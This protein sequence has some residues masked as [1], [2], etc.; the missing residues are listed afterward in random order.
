MKRIFTFTFSLIFAVLM[1]AQVLN[2]PFPC[3]APP[4]LDPWLKK[5][6]QDPSAFDQRSGDTLIVALKIHL[7]ANDNGTARLDNDKFLNTFCQLQE[8]FAASGI[9][10]YMKDG[11][12]LINSTAW[13]NHTDI[14]QGI[15][16]MLSNNVPDAVNCYFVLNPAGNCGYNLPYGG[17]A[18]N[19]SCAGTGSHTWVHELGHAFTMPHPFIGW[20]GKTYNYNNPTPL[21]LTYDYTNFH[22]TL[23]I[24]QAPLDT[25]LVE[26][27]DGS[28]CLD[29][30][31]RFCLTTPD[32]LSYRWDCN[33]NNE[34]LVVQKDP[35]G[36]DFRSD[37]TL[38]MGYASDECQNRFTDDQIA[39][40]RANLVSE[41]GSLLLPAPPGALITE[42][43]GL[44]TPVES[45]LTPYDQVQLKWT[46][47]PG[48]TQYV[49]QV[50]RINYF[51][52]RDFETITSDTSVVAGS[53]LLNK[54]YYWRIRPFNAYSACTEWSEVRKFTTTA[55]TGVDVATGPDFS[56]FPTLSDG[57]S[58]FYIQ[59]SGENSYPVDA[60]LTDIHGKILASNSF[61]SQPSQVQAF[62]PKMSLSKG[63]YFLTLLTDQQRM[64]QK[65]IVH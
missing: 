24:G 51:P 15:D 23:D 41:K 64:V 2:K 12:D 31:D 28:N 49:V 45:Q 5:Y 65:I 1:Q 38:Y 27:V 19:H 30:A 35:N 53:F 42:A 39:A 17:V 8:D 63:V 60:Y 50:S 21:L 52:F 29:A 55:M 62:D 47:V 11:W 25:A 33:A 46:T 26:F 14:E 13:H 20:E 48:A 44:I 61:E 57:S 7:V 59:C 40:M 9:Q 3:G 43:A 58:P 37:G 4:A 54:N 36:V 10:F 32:Y 18:I 16:M 56:V 22:D 34:S 6:L